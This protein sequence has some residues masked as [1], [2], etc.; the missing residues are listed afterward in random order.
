MVNAQTVVTSAFPPPSSRPPFARALFPTFS[1][2][3]FYISPFK[4]HTVPFFV[5]LRWLIWRPATDV[6]HFCHNWRLILGRIAL[7]CIVIL[8]QLKCFLYNTWRNSVFDINTVDQVL[9][10]INFKKYIWSKFSL[11]I[12]CTYR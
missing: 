5:C 2:F 4:V 11:N 12:F 1:R 10:K 3:F 7:I 9:F 8:I 6:R